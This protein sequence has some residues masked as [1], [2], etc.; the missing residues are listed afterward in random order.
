[1]I[2]SQISAFQDY[3]IICYALVFPEPRSLPLGVETNS[4]GHFP[5]GRCSPV[6]SALPLDPRATF[7]QREKLAC[8]LPS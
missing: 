6:C 5:E 7:K 4:V 2:S 1:M 8:P 3:N